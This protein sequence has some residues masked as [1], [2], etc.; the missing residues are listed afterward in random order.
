MENRFAGKIALVTGAGG[1]IGSATA[2]R[3]AQEGAAVA[4]LSRS[5]KK[6]AATQ[7]KLAAIGAR[8]LTY[9][10]DVTDTNAVTTT[11]AQIIRD[12][13]AIDLL[14]NNAGYQGEFK[15]VHQYDLQDFICVMNTN[16]IGAFRILTAV[17]AHMVTRQTGSIVNMSSMAGVYG[18]PNMASYSASKFAVI[19]L[20]QTA[21]KDLAP[22]HIRV[23]AVSPGLMGP[24]YLWE[25]QVQQ[26]S[27]AQTQYFSPDPKTT[28][29]QMLSCVPLRRCGKIT[30]V[31]GAVSFLLSDD[32]SYITGINLPIAGGE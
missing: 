25:R 14:F 2:L 4:L 32:A 21:A 7:Q 11:I 6:L 18:P 1:E 20:T 15:P 10:C 17:A 27:A 28:E 29:Q 12:F 8:A 30:E 16:V 31:P 22:Y 19:G 24:G 9:P 26:Q 23:N 5:E 3:L 13:G